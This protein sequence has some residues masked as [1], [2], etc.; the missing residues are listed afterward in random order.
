MATTD[1]IARNRIQVSSAVSQRGLVSVALWT[2]QVLLALVFLA[3]GSMKLLTP[4]EIMEAQTPL[5]L[6][7]VRFI[8]VCEMAGALGLILPS[9]LRIRPALTPVAAA[10]LVVL[11]V[12]A[13]VLTPVLIGVD[14]VLIA[15]PATVGAVA[16]LVAYGRSRLAPISPR[17]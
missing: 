15:L 5:P 14:A 3:T 17:G 13:T 12:C 2:A 1:V 9:L 16:A 10:C 8:G 7:I 11:M 4:A 6:A